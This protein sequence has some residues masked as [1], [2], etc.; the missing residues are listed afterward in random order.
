MARPATREE[1]ARIVIELYFELKGI[2]F[3]LLNL[4]REES[5]AELAKFA[6]RQLAKN[7]AARASCGG[8]KSRR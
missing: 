1:L 3:M 2:K 8:V 4:I 7:E 5:D 6:K